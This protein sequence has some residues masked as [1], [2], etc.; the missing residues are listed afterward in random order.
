MELEVHGARR[1]S[2]VLECGYERHRGGSDNV[3]FGW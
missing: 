2:R 3:G 1:V